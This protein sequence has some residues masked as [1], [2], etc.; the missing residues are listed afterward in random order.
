MAKVENAK[1]SD[2]EVSVTQNDN[3]ETSCCG[4]ND[5]SIRQGC[6]DVRGRNVETCI[7]TPVSL[8]PITTGAVIKTPVVLAELTVQF[9][10]TSNIELPQ[11]A[12]EIKNIKKKVKVTQ[13]MLIQDTNILF[14]RG[15][16]RKNIDYS[17]RTCANEEGI[18]GNLRHCTVDVP[19]ECTTPVTFNGTT[20]APFIPTTN[21]EY[22]YFRTQELPNGFA[23][24]DKLLSGDL[25]EYNQISTE[26]FNEL[27]Y[28]EL[29]SSRIVEF[30]EYIDR[31]EPIGTAPFEERVFNN[32]EQ[33]MVVF[34]TL[35]LLQ[36]RQVAVDPNG[37][38]A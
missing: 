14:I 28:C 18:C 31:Q 2:V 15:F 13:C 23:E 6:V 3:I 27:P 4:T 36:K 37:D 25:S 12:L 10:V 32:I 7:N 33:K 19:F 1:V 8:D 5:V 22:E 26:F 24:K 34:L 38:L 9:N 16:V 20:P 11:N 17:T 29:I 21:Q 30:D 35:K